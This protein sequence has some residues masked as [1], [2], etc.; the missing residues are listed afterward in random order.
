[1]S[2]D[3][4]IISDKAFQKKYTNPEEC[5]TYTQGLIINTNNID[6]KLYLQNIVA[7]AYALQGN[8]VQSINSLTAEG[9]LVTELTPTDFSRI[10]IRYNLA[11]QYQNVGL[12]EQSSKL[13]NEM[14]SS[15]ALSNAIDKKYYSTVAKLY[16]LQAV[17]FA[18]DT[19]Y[20]KAISS[21]DKSLTFLNLNT[22]EGNLIAFENKVFKASFLLKINK[23]NEAKTIL[24]EL[25]EKINNQNI[26]IFQASFFRIANSQYFFLLKD[27]P[28]AIEN[29]QTALSKIENAPLPNMKANIYDLLSKNY[30]ALHDNSKYL[31]YNKL[32]KDLKTKTDFNKKEGVRFLIK[33][34]ENTQTKKL[35]NTE[36]S[37][38]NKLILLSAFCGLVV[39]VFSF[40]AF[41]ARRKNKDLTKQFQFF[42]KYREIEA[43]KK[44]IHPEIVTTETVEQ[45]N[46]ET[47]KISIEKETEIVQKLD[48]WEKSNAFLSKSMSLSTLSASLSVN[49]KYLSEVI[50]NSKEKNFNGYINELRVNH[51]IY[52][53]KTEPAYLNYKVSYLAEYSG[54]SSHGAFTTVFKNITGMSPNTFI[55]KI[56]KKIK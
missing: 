28:N 51:I 16:Q 20:D 48:E 43:D 49:T 55:E 27:Y 22:Q 19:K 17:N 13:I 2:S 35:S 4:L 21:L 33:Y 6:D 44:T 26:P 8:Y 42:T 18:I 14:L 52:L 7:Q 10:L 53:L 1:M 25:Q 38:R 50:K 56:T 47:R 23:I 29:L 3:F 41:N 45:N 11:D 32:Y 31:H 15:K 34:L 30:L 37:F 12:Y 9:D 40:F 5:V 36:E 54:F 24:D 46:K 39:L